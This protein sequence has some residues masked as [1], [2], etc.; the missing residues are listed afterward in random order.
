MSTRGRFISK[1]R[2]GEGT[3]GTVYE[4]LCIKSKKSYAIKRYN[5]FQEKDGIDVSVIREII[6]LKELKH[7]NIVELYDVLY[8]AQTPNQEQKISIVLELC[9]YDLATYQN[10]ND[11]SLSLDVIKSFMRDMLNG[12]A[13]LHS[14]NVVHRDLKPGNLLISHNDTLKIGDFG[15]SRIENISVMGYVHP[16]ATLWYRSPDV[17]LGYTNYGFHI[18]IW[19]IGC[20]F[21]EMLIGKQ[22]FKGKNE[23]DQLCKIFQLF[24]TPT[25]ETFPSLEKCPNIKMMNEEKYIST[26]EQFIQSPN[27]MR[28][29]D[30]GIDLLKKMLSY[31]PSNRIT[32]A[33]ALKHPYFTGEA[34]VVATETINTIAQTLVTQAFDMALASIQALTY[35]EALAAAESGNA[36]VLSE[37][38]ILMVKHREE[39]NRII[40][41]VTKSLTKLFES[42]SLIGIRDEI[43]RSYFSIFDSTPQKSY[44][45]DNYVD[46]I[47]EQSYASPTTYIVALIYID[48]FIKKYPKFLVTKQNIYR[49]FLV[50]MRVAN[51]INDLRVLNNYHFAAVGG[52]SLES[53]NEL[54]GYFL[55]ALSFDLFFSPSDVITFMQLIVET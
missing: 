32:S 14:K 42:H 40:P 52:I 15:L 24:G 2:L 23:F 31:E 45:I 49:L 11:C 7:P 28:I 48:R 44:K 19:S 41:F 22:L 18:D 34:F 3:F 17:L 20:I 6:L 53:L 30:A 12:V 16:V 54:E 1:S 13:Y 25:R 43:A 38:V 5:K 8:Q 46:R 36:E 10:K 35:T 21:A 55:T 4:V 26:W 27:V 39:Y 50:S 51:K 33:D 9:K 47:M 29:G 37:S